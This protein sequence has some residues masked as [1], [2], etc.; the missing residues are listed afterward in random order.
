MPAKLLF[1][2]KNRKKRTVYLQLENSTKQISICFFNSC[3][4]WGG[5]EKWHFETAHRLREQGFDVTLCANKGA[6]LYQKAKFS[7]MPVRG[8][9]ISNLSF[10]NPLKL[11]RLC[12]FFR[13]HY[14]DHLILN[15][16]ADLKCAGLAARL[17]GVKDIIYRRGS[18][19]PVK[20]S[21]F[22]RFLFQYVVGRVIANSQETKRTLL[23]KNSHL[24]APERITVIYNGINLEVFDKQEV[25][26]TIDRDEKFIIGTLGRLEPEKNQ[27]FLFPVI[28]QIKKS[29]IK[30]KLVI[31]GNGSQE[32][33]LYDL[34]EKFSLTNEVEFTGFVDD[35]KSFMK[36]LDIFVLPSKWEGFGY[37]IIEAQACK[38]PVVAFDISSLPE[39]IENGYNGFLVPMED[40]EAFSEA[41]KKLISNEPLRHQM[42]NNGRKTAQKFD[43]NESIRKLVSYLKQV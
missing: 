20:N 21:V 36:G 42:G 25:D 7:G 1:L 10:L 13:K 2:R 22:N 14:I 23:R 37:V 35:V 28:D 38:L 33:L 6:R 39:T 15:L 12:R 16:P 43:I 19:I 4:A 30:V 5:G 34:R 40:E 24:I 32:Q 26:Q 17:A 31:G 29:G 8:V 11:F 9:R 41:V 3:R 27:A 18:A